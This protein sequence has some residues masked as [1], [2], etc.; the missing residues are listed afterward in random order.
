[1]AKENKKKSKPNNK[2]NKSAPIKAEGKKADKAT[3]KKR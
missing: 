1:M 2:S 3:K